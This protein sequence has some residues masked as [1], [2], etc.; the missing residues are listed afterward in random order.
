MSE[1]ECASL[2][3]ELIAESNVY[4]KFEEITKI[5]S[6]LNLKVPKE[7]RGGDQALIN[8]YIT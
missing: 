2:E 1:A 5:Y 3:T 8:N 6:R 7:K 4:F